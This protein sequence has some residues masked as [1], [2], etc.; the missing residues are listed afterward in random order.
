MALEDDITVLK[1]ISLFSR[2]PDEPLRLLAFGASR[3]KRRK[4]QRLFTAGAPA[5]TAYVVLDGAVALLP[6]GDKDGAPEALL[7]PGTLIGEYALLCESTRPQTAMVVEEGTLL[8]IPRLL[9]RRVLEEY[10]RVAEDLLDAMAARLSAT[11]A[12]LEQVRER[13]LALDGE[14]GTEPPG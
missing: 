14:A 1:G 13:L 2:V 4:G 7:G 5:F 8:E 11:M 6:P 12:G 3:V 9:M 10:P